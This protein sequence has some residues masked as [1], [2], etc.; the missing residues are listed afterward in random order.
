VEISLVPHAFTGSA[1]SVR[2]SSLVIEKYASM[3]G[4][5]AIQTAP[6]AAYW[7]V[8]WN[9]VKYNH[10]VGIQTGDGMWIHNNKVHHNGQLGIGGTGDKINVQTNE[11][12]SNNYAGYSF[13]WEAGGVKFN[14]ALN[15]TVQYNYA[16]DNDGPGFWTDINSQ[17]V[18][19]DSNQATRNKEAGI[20]MELSYNITVSH[21]HVWND[22]F[23]SAGASIWW[24]AGILN[25]DSSDVE[26]YSNQVTDCMNGISG[27]LASRGSNPSGVPYLI[28]N[29]TVHDNTITQTKGIAAGIV[30]STGFDNSVYTSWN[31][32]YQTNTFVLSNPTTYNYFFWLG[33]YWTLAIWNANSSLH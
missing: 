7:N 1:D 31:N 19:I 9:D 25:T 3:A 2:I 17:F 11:V 14:N 26:I 28:K 21:N 33:S 5:G 20:F 32:H 30:K 6:G 18:R 8:E 27:I 12:Y 10:G 4:D 24:G 22:G 16:H 23:N 13:Y 15:V 29:M